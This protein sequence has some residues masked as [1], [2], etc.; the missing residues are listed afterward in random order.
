[1]TALKNRKG[2]SAMSRS[3]FQ[4]KVERFEIVQLG[5]SE[6]TFAVLVFKVH[7]GG[8]TVD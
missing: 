2:E 6:R 5:F 8:S 3:G 1:M 4:W 7:A